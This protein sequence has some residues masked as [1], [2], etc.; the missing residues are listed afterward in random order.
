[1]NEF[2]GFKV[3]VGRHV[4]DIMHDPLGSLHS[5]GEHR[6]RSLAVSSIEQVLS[7]FQVTRY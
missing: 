3:L 6:G 7:G 1:M 5:S 2:S 4:V